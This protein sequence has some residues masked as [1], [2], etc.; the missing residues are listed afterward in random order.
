MADCGTV[1]AYVNRRCRCGNCKA[2]ARESYAVIRAES[3]LRRHPWV[4]PQ[5]ILSVLELAA[6]RR[7][8]ANW[9]DE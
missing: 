1:S 3:K 5:H 8:W 4:E 9:R 6:W 7:A 2:A